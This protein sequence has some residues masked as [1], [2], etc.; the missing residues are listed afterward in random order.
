M[1]EY[2]FQCNQIPL[3]VVTAAVHIFLEISAPWMMCI[4]T[5]FFVLF[6][7][8]RMFKFDLSTRVLEAEV[9]TQY[10]RVYFMAHF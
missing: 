4:G 8:N 9:S 1:A 7:L 5:F 6:F 2:I 3:K 10:L